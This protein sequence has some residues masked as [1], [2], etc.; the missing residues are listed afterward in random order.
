MGPVSRRGR[1]PHPDILTPAEWEVLELV[2]HG[3]S[4]RGIARARNTSLDAVKFHVA[5]LLLKLDAP[6]RA[7]LRAYGG[8]RA[9]SALAKRRKSMPE[10]LKLGR[11]AQVSRHV[12]DIKKA[13]S[14]YKDVLGLPHLFTFG[15]LAFFDCGGTRLYL[16][17]PENGHELHDE[18]VLYFAVDDIQGAFETLKSRGAKFQGAPHMIHKHE[19]GM[20][21]WM[22]F[23]EDPDGGLLA[24]AAQV[25][26][27]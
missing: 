19:N 12:S 7:A 13:E 14:W 4:N 26:G 3:F 25:G 22:A 1:P 27:A 2:R 5:N 17:T 18:S 24:I 10:G 23:F 9:D 16:S 21:E 6:D 20:E 8:V 11:I 15:N